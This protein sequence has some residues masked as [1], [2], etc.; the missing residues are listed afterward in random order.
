MTVLRSETPDD[1]AA[2]R[3]VNDS[4]FPQPAEARLVDALRGQ[5]DPWISLVADR[6][7]RVIG[8][9]LFTK[10]TVSG[11]IPWDAIAL[12]PMAIHPDFQRQGVGT[13]LVEAG[14][15]ACKEQGHTVVF[16][17]GHPTFYARFGFARA[18]P[19]GL[20]CKWN[21]PDEAFMV[22]ELEQGALAGRSGQVEYHP[23]FDGCE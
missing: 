12:G 16:V 9:I 1:V 13:L 10:V 2:I 11:E 23:E 8:H 22:A 6:D 15:L 5:V 20:T 3:E 18:K 7:G 19:R 21:V 14:L 17:L 4:A